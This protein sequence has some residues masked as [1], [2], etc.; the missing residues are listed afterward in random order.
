MVRCVT[1]YSEPERHFKSPRRIRKW[2]IYTY[3]KSTVQKWIDG[4][5]ID[6][7]GYANMDEWE[8]VSYIPTTSTLDMIGEQYFCKQ[9]VLE[10]EENCHWRLLILNITHE[11]KEVKA[12]LLDPYKNNEAESK[13]LRVAVQKLKAFPRA[14]ERGSIMRNVLQMTWKCIKYRSN[15][16]IQNDGYN[17]GVFVMYFMHC[18]GKGVQMNQSFDPNKFRITIPSNLLTKFLDMKGTCLYCFGENGTQHV[19]CKYCRRYAHLG[20]VPG[21]RKTLAEWGEPNTEFICKLCACSV[22]EWMIR[23]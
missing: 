22:R 5:V 17:C 6:A 4:L 23:H 19:M 14:C 18:L 15:R 20:C 1:I 16:P 8:K 3:K 10:R 2:I 21:K 9:G 13:E 11:S 12:T 7:F